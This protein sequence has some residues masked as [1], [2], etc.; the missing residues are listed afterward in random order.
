[1]QKTTKEKNGQIITRFRYREVE[2][3]N[4]APNNVVLLKRGEIVKIQKMYRLQS[5]SENVYNIK[6]TLFQKISEA[7]SYPDKASNVLD[8]FIVKESVTPTYCSLNE[9]ASKIILLYI[10][11]VLGEEGILYAMPF[12][13]S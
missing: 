5:T 1:M 3:F 11:D 13:H 8:I 7:F 2:L 12:L 4:K 9:I 10:Y 6:G